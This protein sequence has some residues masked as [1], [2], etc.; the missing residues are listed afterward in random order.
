[1]EGI[2]REDLTQRGVISARFRIGDTWLVLVQPTRDDLVPGRHLRD[3]G[4]G[5]MLV[6]LGV[7]DL[8]ESTASVHASGA[9]MLDEK[10]RHGLD[11]WKIQD[12]SP[13]D[14]CGVPLQFTQTDSE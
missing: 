6:S 7:A 1:M 12:L 8:A 11:G 14:F 4:E 13:D 10:P 9:S 5:V 3:H 2:I